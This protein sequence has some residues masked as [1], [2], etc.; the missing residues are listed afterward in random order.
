[1]AGL[2]FSA[3]IEL[4]KIV[5][6][7]TEI[8][9]LKADMMA[10]A[11]KPNNGNAMKSLEKQLNKATKELDKYMKK[12]ALMK[13]AYEEILKSDNTVKVVHE[14]TQA[15]QSTNKWIV[16]NTQAVK[17]A[18]TEIKKL[19]ADFAALNDTEKVGDKGYNILRQVE[20]QVAIRK[21]EE[22]A[23]RANI[24]AQKEQIIQNNSEEGSITQL[25]KQLSLMLNLYDNMGR[26]KRSGS[27]GKELLAQIRIVQTELNEAEQASG[28]FQRNVG[29]YSSAFNGLGMSIQQIAREL[30][31]ATMGI[32]MFFLAI[33]NNLPI[34]F[35]EVQ[36]AR[37]EYAAYIEELKKGNTDVQK[38]APVWKQIISG[39]VSWN[40][41]LVVGI[42]LLTAYGKEIFN[43]IGGLISTQRA[44]LDLLS[45]EQEMALA[46]REAIRSSANER[47]ELDILYSK[48]RNVSLSER[49]RTA[50]VNEWISKFPQYANILEGEKVNLGNLESAYRTL[51]NEIYKNA[52][53]RSYVDKLAD[54]SIKKDKE[55]IK[56]L[57]QKLTVAKAEERL[58]KQEEDF[59]K[60][61]KEGFGTATAKIDARKKVES[62]RRDLEKQRGIYNDI[63][64][65]LQ[66]YEN[67]F[68]DISNHINTLDLFPQPQEGTYDYW[69]QQIRNAD[70]AL[71]QIKDTYL[72]VLK[73]GS[74]Q[75]VPEDVV[76]QYNSLIKQKREAERKLKIY[77]EKG[78]NGNVNELTSQQ[79]KIL[80][81]ESKYA[82]ERRRQA[83]DLEYQ[84]VQ[85]RISAMND[86]YQKIKA[87]RDLDN[88]KEIQ[89][90]QRQKEDA[91]RVEIEAQKKVFDEQEKLK[92][93]QNKKYKIKT[94]DAST[95]DTSNI[96][97]AF[98]SII[99]YVSNRQKDDLI[100]EQE[101]AWNEY[102]IKFGNYQ[103]KRQAIIEKYN[104]A[105]ETAA[106]AGN[107]AALEG[108]KKQY[109]EQLDEQ[110]GKTT[111]AMAD[112]FEDASTKSVSAIQ[113]I[114]D[115]Y[116]TLIKY[117]S[118]TDKDI[119]ITDLKGI[120]F[121]D[122]DIEKIERGEISIKDVTD[123]I[124][125]LKDELKGKSPWK[126]FV[127]DLEKGIEAIKKGGNDSKKVG[128][129]ITDIGNAVTSFAPALGEFGSNIANIFGADDSTITGITDALGGLG[130]T[131][132]GVGQ[133]MS[134]DIVGGAMSAVSGISSVVSAFEG[135]FGADYSGYEK[136]K[137]QYENLISIWDEL[138]TK[139]MDYIDID[140]GTEAIKAAEEAEQLV[141]INISRQRQLI[142]RL[143]SSGAS[144]G[145]HSLGYRINERLSKEDYQ[146]ISGLVGEKITAEYQLWDLSSEQIEKI[147]SDEKL[148]SVLDTVNKDFVTYLQNIVDYGEQLTEI[149]QKEK[150]AITGIG[151][152]EFKNGY[153][154]LLSDLDSTNEDFAD[155][156]EQ[157]LQKAIFQSLLANKYKE[158][159]QRLYDSWA[160]Y[161]KDGLTS[162]EAQALRNMQQNLTNSLL[163]ER[164][165]LMQ[166]FG[167]QSDSVR[168]A[169]QKGIA[170]ASQDSVDENNG[171]LAVMQGHTYSINENVSRMATGIDG[172]LNY[173][174]AN[175]SATT[176]ID[177]T[178]K[179]IESQSKDILNHLA[180][181][182]NYTSNLVE[183]RE[184]MY[185]MKSGIDTLN[186]KGITLKR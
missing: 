43:Y 88:K 8:K 83:E 2:K 10:L 42:T 32:N 137:A 51:S 17:E 85:A 56:R 111:R 166:D 41:A 91:I 147:L 171:R 110:Y 181:I 169:S 118:G 131:A 27:S 39:V 136:M 74:T 11:G 30:P 65:N 148:V 50:A 149:A 21:R 173:S 86:G 164:D 125:G 46:R 162:D 40:T 12:Y 38:V 99:G 123:A 150:E 14:E 1:M 70:S 172:L 184:Y 66:T 95:V 141:N 67:N 18:D 100:R 73:A 4:D 176:D 57:N 114:I 58:R 20:Q 55:E 143:A 157:Y 121:T 128:Q 23:V 16:A 132:V 48:L 156:F 81:I 146:R 7:R 63:L 151:F 84:I 112:L 52:V 104:N 75:G 117:M 135:L 98:D 115:K 3:D 106:T 126:A 6:L 76:K 127:S 119:S 44:T 80:G 33:S 152:D 142:K 159:I 130:T 34:F 103:Q 183:I 59:N 28:R 31:A 94:F 161:G 62:A 96:S 113:D 77:D 90:L 120:G 26:I 60:Q 36:K 178:A 24:K 109:L 9:G 144:I 101:S 167:W 64:T 174:V 69:Q 139:K 124:R 153:A 89:D 93:R 68:R 108:E 140:Y 102:L 163:A 97:S 92:A 133:I 107:A 165:K 177:K 29:N 145:S 47:V 5:K 22:E 37:K 78:S 154:N 72:E 170:T 25:R 175:L 122:K 179:A 53:A 134:G 160:E 61:E 180:N 82:L 129:G 87:Q 49:E 185:A 105:I 168:E 138:I 13:K 158:Q 54:I 19:K 182:D 71:K 35:D 155:N 116:E 45:A 79:D 186:T 15:L